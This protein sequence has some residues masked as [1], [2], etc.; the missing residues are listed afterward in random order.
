MKTILDY[1]M[2]KRFSKHIK[3]KNILKLYNF[4][5]KFIMSYQNNDHY[6]NYLCKNIRIRYNYNLS[7]CFKRY[8]KYFLIK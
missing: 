7:I 6:I 4:F 8:R 1:Y 3:Y 2:I 5:L